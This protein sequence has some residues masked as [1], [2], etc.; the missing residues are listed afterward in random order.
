MACFSIL[1]EG[2]P[3]FAAPVKRVVCFSILQ[4]GLP[5]PVEAC[6]KFL[7]KFARISSENQRALFP[8]IGYLLEHS[9]KH[10]G[11]PAAI[12][13][14]VYVCV[15]CM[16]VCVYVCVCVYQKELIPRANY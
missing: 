15:V 12:E 16:Y 5:Q 14:C 10:P 13:T 1:Q 6:C 2:L 4:E 8:H 3:Q 11:K 7:C 9:E